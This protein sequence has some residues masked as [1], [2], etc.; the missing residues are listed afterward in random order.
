ML[1]QKLQQADLS[2]NQEGTPTST[3]FDDVYFSNN[4]GQQ[5][6]QYV[7]LAGN[8]LS[9]RWQVHSHRHFVIAETGFGT[10]LNFL[11]SWQA[12]DE[13]KVRQGDQESP[14]QRL[15]FI[16]FEKYPLSQ[17][18]LQQAL[19]QWP[20]LQQ[21]AAQLI[22]K[23]PY[24]TPGCH[25]L[26]FDNGRVVLDLWLGDIH[27]SLPNMFVPPQG[28]VDAWFLD[29]FAP[30][31]NPDMWSP[32]LFS[33]MARLAKHD[34]TLATFTAAGFVRRGLIDAGFT[35]AKR[36]GYGY[37]REMLVG[38]FERDTHPLQRDFTERA[39]TAPYQDVCIIGGGLA[40][41]SL[42]FAL[43][44]KGVK[45]HLHCQDHKPAQG[46]SGNR[47]GALY[48]LLTPDNATNSH[49]YCHAFQFSQ[50]QIEAFKAVVDHDFCGVLELA[51]RDKAI[52]K[53][54]KVMAAEYPKALVYNTSAKQSEELAGVEI[55]LP[56]L[57]YPDGAWLSPRQL[58]QALLEDAQKSGL[59]TL[60]L[61]S[62]IIAFSE[63]KQGVS[64]TDQEQKNYQA[65]AIILA[66]GANILQFEQ[67]A[68][69]P[70][71]PV[72]GQVSHID[73]NTVLAPL[74]R[75]LCYQGYL[76]PAHNGQH[77]IGASYG[78]N[79]DD[80]AFSEAEQQENKQ[81][82]VTSFS[83]QDWPNTVDVST[84]KGRVS[85]RCGTR[86]NLP[87]VGKLPNK[88][89]YLTSALNSNKKEVSIP[90]ALSYQ[91]V[92]AFTALGSRGICTAPLL[93]EL[94]ASE[95]TAEPLPVGLDGLFNL[96]PNR[97]WVRSIKKGR[98]F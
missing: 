74:K 47:Q 29:G 33:Q 14:L 32:E 93:A 4:N 2:W 52:A 85:V 12:F 39:V 23:Y 41:A 6:S 59:L 27:D 65:S 42:A 86:D 88:P 48:P 22:A 37:K 45:V 70:L 76:T 84:L 26:M 63:S 87:F 80:T 7:F 62:Q 17:S 83:Q 98:P 97:Y 20:Q 9:E 73:T 1:N 57:C 94:M 38:R 53:R 40:S 51:Y 34:A 18:D 54:D 82:I 77:C 58:T 78:R 30:S 68:E 49:F 55:D 28:L 3:Q 25:R 60:H 11:N 95:L 36:K 69:L 24:A 43:V 50:Q 72:R 8:Q 89:A 66:N 13:F 81:K 79:K 16:S 75:V 19:Q 35:M 92:F 91:H 71:F 61:N 90:E 64:I 96:N 15:Y 31:K 21:Y 5:E 46:A 10:G 67:A 56:G 44:N